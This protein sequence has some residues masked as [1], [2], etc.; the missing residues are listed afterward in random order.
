MLN[1]G[2]HLFNETHL[3]GLRMSGCSTVDPRLD[4]WGTTE[5]N[6]VMKEQI[7]HVGCR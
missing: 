1:D 7:K 6:E 3:F 4:V 5:M 2:T